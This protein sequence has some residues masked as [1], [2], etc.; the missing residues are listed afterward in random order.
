MHTSQSRHASTRA[1]ICGAT[2]L[3]GITLL[4]HLIGL[5]VIRGDTELAWNFLA[6]H[7]VVSFPTDLLLH[8][9]GIG[10]PA[11]SF[12]NTPLFLIGAM[13][14]V[15][16]AVGAVCGI[17]FWIFWQWLQPTFIRK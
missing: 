15:N 11:Q 6:L 5:V 12:H 3:G 16:A 4:T 7:M 8:I 10:W 2:I 1:A 9:C 14:A 13:V 17:V